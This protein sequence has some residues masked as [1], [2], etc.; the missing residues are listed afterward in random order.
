MSIIDTTAPA[1]ARKYSNV[2][3][4]EIT[5]EPKLTASGKPRKA[6]QSSEDVD[7]IR[8]EKAALRAALDALTEEERAGLSE[9]RFALWGR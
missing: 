6:F 8:R 1:T 4:W 5:L 2:L 9:F 3:H 7:Q